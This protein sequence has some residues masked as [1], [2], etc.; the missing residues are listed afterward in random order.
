LNFATLSFCW[1]L[2]I[3]AELGFFAA[4][5]LGRLPRLVRLV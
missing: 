3:P 2:L 5:N 4:S 1:V